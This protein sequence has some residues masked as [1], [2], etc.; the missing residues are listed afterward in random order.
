MP[1]GKGEEREQRGRGGGGVGTCHETGG[2]MWS[3]SVGRVGA[4]AAAG[5]RAAAPPRR[6]STHASSGHVTSEPRGCPWRAGTRLGLVPPRVA[7]PVHDKASRGGGGS[8]VAVGRLKACGRPAHFMSRVGGKEG[9]TSTVW[10]GG[11]RRHARG[12]LFRRL[13]LN[14]R[15]RVATVWTSCHGTDLNAT[16][17]RRFGG[18]GQPPRLARTV[19]STYKRLPFVDHALNLLT[20]P[21]PPP[22][23][24]GGKGWSRLAPRPPCQPSVSLSAMSILLR[25]PV[26]GVPRDP[27]NRQP[28]GT[29]AAACRSGAPVAGPRPPR[30]GR[31]AAGGCPPP[32]ASLTT[33]RA[34]AFA[35]GATDAQRCLA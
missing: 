16:A 3:A 5:P 13:P 7:P 17:P 28:R 12:R 4:A 1:R 30:G 29:G 25:A 14:L 6:P 31:Q 15:P 35:G 23:Q 21:L 19:V 22:P 27:P 18:R 24:L 11:R 20:Q 2:S 10:V 33:L 32:A 8:P 26:G 34:F 9:P